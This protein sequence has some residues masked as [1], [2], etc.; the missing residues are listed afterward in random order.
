VNSIGGTA[1]SCQPS[2]TA[3]FRWFSV[4]TILTP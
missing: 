4:V 3:L 1:A 2:P